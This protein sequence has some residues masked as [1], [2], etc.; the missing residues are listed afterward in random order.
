VLPLGNLRK[1]SGRKDRFGGMKRFEDGE[2]G[3]LDGDAEEV[4][5]VGEGSWKPSC[6]TTVYDIRR[7]GIRQHTT[8]Q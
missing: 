1:E 7:R 4:V 8:N 5:C 3:V 6:L 2:A